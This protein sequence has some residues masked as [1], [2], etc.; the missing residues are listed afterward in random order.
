MHPAPVVSEVDAFDLP[1][2]L[3]ECEV[4]WQAGSSV[5]GSHHVAGDLVGGSEPMAC[6]LLAWLRLQPRYAR[7]PVFVLTGQLDTRDEDAAILREIGAWLRT[8]GEAIYGTRPWH[9][10]GEGP[11]EINEL[12]ARVRVALGRGITQQCFPGQGELRVI[13]LDGQ[14]EQML[15]NLVSN[16]V[17]FT[18]LRE[19]AEIEIGYLA[20]RSPTVYFVK[21]NGVGFNMQYADRLFGVFQ[22]LHRADVIAALVV[23]RFDLRR[24]PDDLQQ[25][26]QHGTITVTA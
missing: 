25:V 5:R 19:K 16:A 24:G 2:W 13:G 1:E 10:F 12:T 9:V 7:T 6:D 14:L 3:G 23:E 18:A 8:N 22:R 15:I 4:T 26:R 21:D 11:T 17:K 20:D